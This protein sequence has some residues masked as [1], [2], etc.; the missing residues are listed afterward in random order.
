MQIS[1]YLFFDGNCEQAMNF[2][3]K[4]FGGKISAIM[5][6]SEAP[7]KMQMPNTSGDKIMHAR[8]DIGTMTL[9]GSDC[10]PNMF[11]KP[12]GFRVMVGFDKTA[13][14]E[15]AFNALSEG[16]NVQM[17]FQQTFWAHRFGMVT[18]RFGTPWMINCE[19]AD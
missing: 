11:D 18:D 19:K 7:K 6:N 10:P 14:G 1:T 9:L 2:Y 16:G 17:P 12:Q 4:T 13:D 5:R 8:L 15:R 3:E